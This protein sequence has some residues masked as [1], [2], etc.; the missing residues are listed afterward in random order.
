[1]KKKEQAARRVLPAELAARAARLL[2]LRGISQGEE[3]EYP[4][5]A[6]HPRQQTLAEMEQQGL[7]A[8]WDR[9]W[10]ARDLYRVTEQGTAELMLQ[11]K[12]DEKSGLI[13]EMRRRRLDPDGRREFLRERGYEPEYWPILHDQNAH[14]SVVDDW[15]CEGGVYD[16]VWED[17]S[18]LELEERPAR[19]DPVLARRDGLPPAVIDLDEQASAG[20]AAGGWSQTRSAT[21][22]S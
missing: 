16:Y 9:W 2:I 8:R 6:D 10:P 19:E 17:W 21:D 20:R 13:R 5:A 15:S 14:W 18:E 7:V 22:V 3:I 12:P 11:Y 4:A 1:M